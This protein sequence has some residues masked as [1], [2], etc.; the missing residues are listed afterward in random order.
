VRGHFALG[1]SFTGGL[2]QRRQLLRDG[3]E[4]LGDAEIG[5]GGFPWYRLGTTEKPT[6]VLWQRLEQFTQLHQRPHLQ[7]MR[8]PDHGLAHPLR[9]GR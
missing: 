1:N 3:R 5:V 7:R 9:D 6:L 2:G 4:F 8:L